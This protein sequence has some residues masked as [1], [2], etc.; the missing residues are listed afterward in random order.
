M[1]KKILAVC[2]VL[3]LAITAITGASLAYLQDTDTEDNIFT[4]GNVKIDLYETFDESLSELM[5]ST[6]KDADGKV[7]NAVEKEVYVY[8]EGKN[9]AY[10]RVHI[11]IPQILDN[12]DPN[13]DA[14]QNVL[15]F[16]FSKDSIA[17]GKWNWTPAL[18]EE[19]AVGYGSEWNF[20]TA[21]I[22]GVWYNVYVVTYETPLAAGSST[23]DAMNQVYLD[24][25][26]SN[27]DIEKINETLR[28]NWHIYVAAEG[29]QEQ[30][31]ADAYT[32]LNTA[33]GVPGTY[34]IDWAAAEGVDTVAGN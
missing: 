9:D 1:K 19:G 31:F 30:G 2:L 14:S 27:G 32:A 17:D 20:Y 4:V 15:H 10:V 29:V 21:E 8:N 23:I 18:G 11:A 12:G 34:T 3:I 33:F 5:P 25:K 16:N 6:G 22:D 7:I 26:V 28:E 24:G 13:F